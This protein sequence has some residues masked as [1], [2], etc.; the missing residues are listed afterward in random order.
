MILVPRLRACLK[1]ELATGW[2]DVG[3]D[4]AMITTSALAT[5]P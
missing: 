4:P 5:S 3:L 2:L 1:K